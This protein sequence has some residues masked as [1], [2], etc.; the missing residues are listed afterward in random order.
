LCAFNRYGKGKFQNPGPYA[1]ICA[2]KI[3]RIEFTLP[4]SAQIKAPPLK[5]ANFISQTAAQ[6]FAKISSL[7]SARA[8]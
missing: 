2:P 6:N 4:Q 1:P 3:A 5:S 7:N 8:L